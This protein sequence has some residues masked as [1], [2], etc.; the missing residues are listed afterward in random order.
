MAQGHIVSRSVPAIRLENSRPRL[1]RRLRIDAD[2]PSGHADDPGTA[3]GI[4]P[5]AAFAMQPMLLFGVPQVW[6]LAFWGGLWGILFV[7]VVGHLP[8]GKLYWIDAMI[9]AP[10]RRRWWPGL[11]S[12][13]SKACRSAM[14]GTPPASRPR[15]SPTAPGAWA[16]GCSCGLG[17]NGCA[18]AE[19][20]V[21]PCTPL[22][23]P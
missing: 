12:L 5:D 8:Q 20:R 22:A 17:T 18:R 1:Y 14:A 11:W 7:W 2:V 23:R 6:S 19:G 15:C 3:L 13:P 10:W 4:V 21:A 16:P 9:L